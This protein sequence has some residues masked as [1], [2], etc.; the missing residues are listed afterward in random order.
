MET[1]PKTLTLKLEI[2]LDIADLIEYYED[3]G[4][5]PDTITLDEMVETLRGRALDQIG[6]NTM[7]FAPIYD[8]NNELVAGEE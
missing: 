7:Q 6:Y 4:K 8:D 1:L 3:D 2:E 5:D